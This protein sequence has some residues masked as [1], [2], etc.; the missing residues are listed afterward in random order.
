MYMISV[1][2]VC[3]F[4]SV[5]SRRSS[6]VYVTNGLGLRRRGNFSSQS[7]SYIASLARSRQPPTWV[8]TRMSLVVIFTTRSPD[9]IVK[10][11]AVYRHLMTPSWAILLITSHVPN[12]WKPVHVTMLDWVCAINSVAASGDK[13]AYALRWER[14]LQSAVY[15]HMMTPSWAILLITSHVPNAWKPVHVTMIDWVCAINSVAAS[16]D[17]T[18]Y[19]LRWERWLLSAPYLIPPCPWPPNHYFTKLG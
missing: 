2:Y 5:G 18:A 19:A 12:A 9:H 8:R 4:S 15:R 10:Q 16:G 14:W 7:L 3:I 1:K 6:L 11:S 13:T 17:K